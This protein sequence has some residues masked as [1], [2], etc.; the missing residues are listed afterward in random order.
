MLKAQFFLGLLLNQQ[1]VKKLNLKYRQKEHKV[2]A[3]F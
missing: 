3:K 1:Q 2:V